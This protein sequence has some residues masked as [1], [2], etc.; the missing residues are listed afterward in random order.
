MLVSIQTL[1]AAVLM[2]VTRIAVGDV[3][4]TEPVAGAQFSGSGG[5][6]SIDLKWMDNGAN[7]PVDDITSF[8]FTLETGP[9]NHIQAVKKL[10]ESVPLSAITKV[11]DT[12]SYTLQFPSGIIGNG[13]YYIQVYSQVQGGGYTNNYSPRFELTSMG[14]TSSAT[15]SDSTQPPGETLVAGT[16]TTTASV[17][18][19][20]FT[21]YYTQQTGVSR[22]A[23]MQ[24]QPGSKITATTWTKKFP[25]SAV[26][27]YST[28]R[29]TLAQETT[30]TPGWSYVLS[31]GINF[32]TPAPY[33]TDNGGW[34]NPKQ[35]QSLST[36]K[37]NIKKRARVMG[38]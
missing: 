20:S 6:V 34:Q 7:P 9:N 37:I 5:T 3:Q 18:T 11:G 10:D 4:V 35:R 30:I 31:S 29:N 17:D 33:P 38:N 21:L 25:T 23:P 16:G 2:L 27:Y 36:R 32:A 8:T 14:G 19:R 15:F 26:T 13:Q 1:F 12:Y 24:M 28:Y 22:F